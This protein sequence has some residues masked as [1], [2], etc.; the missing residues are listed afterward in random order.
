MKTLV[1][2]VLYAVFSLLL[3]G[4]FTK[5]C[6]CFHSYSRRGRGAREQTR[7]ARGHT[8]AFCQV[9]HHSEHWRDRENKRRER[10]RGGRR[11]KE[12]REGVKQLVTAYVCVCVFAYV[13]IWERLC[14]CGS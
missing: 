2:Q 3:F 14:L 9:F 8:T 11:G 6:C 12:E 7:R 1:E 5:S 13:Y 4:W 10:G